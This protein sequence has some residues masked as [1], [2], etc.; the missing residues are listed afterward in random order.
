[1]ILLFNSVILQIFFSVC[2]SLFTDGRNLKMSLNKKDAFKECVSQVSEN[3]FIIS[4]VEPDASIAAFAFALTAFI[5][6]LSFVF[7]SPLPNTLTLSV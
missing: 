6:K 4:K 1:M 2:M 3:Y 7:S 5:L